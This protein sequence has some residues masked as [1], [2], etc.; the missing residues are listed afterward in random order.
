M[1][2]PRDTELA[3]PTLASPGQHALPRRA[4]EHAGEPLAWLNLDSDAAALGGAAWEDYATS[5][6]LAIDRWTLLIAT[7]NLCARTQLSRGLHVMTA[8]FCWLY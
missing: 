4:R 2:S 6:M 3:A 7:S 5:K 1:P 8:G